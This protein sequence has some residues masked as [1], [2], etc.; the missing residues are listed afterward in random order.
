MA[1]ASER[2][3]R[4]K[5]VSL[6]QEDNIN[7]GDHNWLLYATDFYKKKIGCGDDI[8]TSFKGKRIFYVA[9]V[10]RQKKSLEYSCCNT[11]IYLFY[12]QIFFPNFFDVV[13]CNFKKWIRMHPRAELDF[14]V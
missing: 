13:K 12:K 2:N 7:Q 9:C 10:K 5:I 6:I 14:R 11:K 3:K 8:I 1:K 4:N